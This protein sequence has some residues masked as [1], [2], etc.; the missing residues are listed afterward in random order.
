MILIKYNQDE[1]IFK[2]DPLVVKKIN[3]LGLF[4]LSF[5][6]ILFP[7]LL[8]NSEI[9][10][11]KCDRLNTTINCHISHKKLFG[12]VTIQN[13]KIDNISAP[14]VINNR[15]YLQDIY[16]S[17]YTIDELKINNLINNL[18]RNQLTITYGNRFNNLF[19]IIILYPLLIIAGFK[20]KKWQGNYL[21]F[22]GKNKTILHSQQKVKGEIIKELNFSDI[23]NI[24]TTEKNQQNREKIYQINLNLKTVNNLGFLEKIWID[25]LKSETQATQLCIMINNF[26]ATKEE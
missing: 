9:R 15:V 11:L 22:N 13:I 12:L 3:R 5:A 26:I 18:T 2:T 7:P 10:K 25:D 20:M 19:Q 16:W 6:L 21:L 8:Y 4:I 14:T 23:K 17:K 24:E 1:L